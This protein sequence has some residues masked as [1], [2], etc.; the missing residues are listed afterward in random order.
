MHR[1][2]QR[3]AAVCLLVTLIAGTGLATAHDIAPIVVTQNAFVGDP[4][5]GIVAA[6][7]T[8]FAENPD[9][10][11]AMASTTKTMTLLV[12][13]EA[14][15]AQ[16]VELPD[17]VTVS[18]YAVSV[19]GSAMQTAGG[20]ELETGE[21]L[22]VADVLRAMMYAS[23]N[24][25]AN[26]LAEHVA[27][28]VV[29]TDAD[30]NDFVDL[31]NAKATALGLTGTHFVNPEGRG[32]P[33]HFTTARELAKIWLAGVQHALFRQFVAPVAGP[34]PTIT[35]SD[36]VTGNP[37]TYTLFHSTSY[38]GVEGWKN[39]RTSGCSYCF[40]VSA[41][42]IGRQAVVTFLN[43]T[44][45][46]AGINGDAL[47]LL[48]AGFARIFHPDLRGVSN[49]WGVASNL[50][51]TCPRADR[52]VT[53]LV[54]TADAARLISWKTNVQGSSQTTQS[55]V[56]FPTSKGQGSGAPAELD[57]I[58]LSSTRIVTAVRRGSTVQLR[59]WSV[60]TTGNPVP[61]AVASAGPASQIEL[62]AVNASRFVTA[63]VNA[64]GL[65][66]V[67][68][69]D[70]TTG[71][72][73][74]A[75]ALTLRDTETLAGGTATEVDVAVAAT[76]DLNGRRT[77]ATVRQGPGP[78]WFDAWRIAADGQFTHVNDAVTGFGGTQLSL[79]PA[80][81]DDRGETF[82][83]NYYALA[84]RDSNGVI[85]LIYASTDRS[86]AEIGRVGTAS[87]TDESV[88]ST[89]AVAF[90]K[91]GLLLSVR[92]A[93]GKLKQIVIESL[94][95][96]DGTVSASRI[97]SHVDA[98]GKTIGVCA[99]ASPHAEGDF[100]TAMREDSTGTVRI[101]GW[102]IGDRP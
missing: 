11:M 48:D 13:V 38:P 56:L 68:T 14:M 62:A 95:N 12:T 77:F 52:A 30:V 101:R 4:L 86:L 31:M 43:G 96:A 17:V 39:G 84:M 81:V 53:P 18:A 44:G 89:S 5:F 70:V 51:L 85:R 32:R 10:S 102:R 66:E 7:G 78:A 41:R 57:A 22:P 87:L 16:K 35:T 40:V 37:K 45:G 8:L 71:R 88:T 69:W 93:G 46:G 82:P 29:G 19:G 100:I 47:P 25:A 3:S 36:P 54:D 67:R 23:D 24:H 26:A 15:E 64:A 27:L 72:A 2:L 76:P 28:K 79:V 73:G 55:N 1:G 50:A 92:T 63:A 9:V 99:L 74:A 83:P 60:P 34:N 91:G 6:A 98:T 21:Q 80:T 59:L 42:R 97:S 90:G 75:S 49:S 94:R 58:S 61:G 33:N 65:L 20:E